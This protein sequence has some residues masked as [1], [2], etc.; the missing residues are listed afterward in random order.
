MLAGIWVGQRAFVGVSPEAFR[1]HVLSL[2]MLIAGL[3]VLRALWALLGWRPVAGQ[4]RSSS[5]LKV[6]NTR[7]ISTHSPRAL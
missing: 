5:R 7:R 4:H 6:W 2:L 1:R 3:S